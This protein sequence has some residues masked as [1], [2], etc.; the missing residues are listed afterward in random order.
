VVDLEGGVGFGAE[1]STIQH[2]EL[3]LKL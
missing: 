3:F 2:I 1:A